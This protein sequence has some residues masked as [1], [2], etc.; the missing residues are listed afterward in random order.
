MEKNLRRKFIIISMSAV[1]IVLFLITAVI[2]L[3]NYYQISRN[4]DDLINIIAENDGMFPKHKDNKGNYDLPPKMS[5]ET[6]FST[7]FFTARFGK[8]NN[9]MAVDTGNVSAISSNQAVK[10][11][12]SVFTS[13]KKEGITDDYK[14]KIISTDYGNLIVFIDISNELRMFNDFLINSI[15]IFFVGICAIF[16]LIYVFS[17]SAIKP[18]VESYEKQK[19]F[20]TD[21]SHELKTPLAVINTNADV[22]EMEC[23]ES[24]WTKSIHRQIERMSKLISGL[25]MLSRMDEESNKII[26]TEFS[27]SDAVNE[28]AEPFKEMA[29]LKNKKINL[30]IQKNLTYNGDEEMIR[31]LIYILLDNAIKYSKE[32]SDINLS[33]NRYVNKCIIKVQNESENLKKGKYDKLFERFYRLDSSRNSKKGGYGIGLSIAKSIVLKHK[34]KITAE[35]LDG[36]IFTISAMF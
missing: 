8:E 1:F 18:I 21:A 36:K 17:K 2:D 24:E 26:K 33:L 15:T 6:P 9:L 28:A 11:A 35:S 7:R 23:G 32:N 29:E 19:Q 14:Y 31:Q 16:I 13:G 34:G 25:I 5:K 22:L 12:N 3:T 20:I 30:N 27:I 4:S 10:Y